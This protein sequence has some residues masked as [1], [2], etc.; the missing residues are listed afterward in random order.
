MKKVLLFFGLLL[1]VTCYSLLAL[2]T[3][4]EDTTTPEYWQNKINE[5]QTKLDELSGQK[6]TLAST[7]AYLNTQISLTQSQIAKTEQEL[8]ILEKEILE[9]SKKI[10]SLNVS[11]DELTQ[12]YKKR[13]SATYIQ[14]RENVFLTTLLNSKGIS[15]FV[16][17]YKYLQVIQNHDKKI[18]QAMERSRQNY[19]LQKSLKEQKQNELETLNNK[20]TRQKTDLSKQ[21]QEKQKLLEITNNDE[22]KFQQLLAEAIAELSAIQAIIS[23]KGTE[24]EVRD[25]KSEEN[26]ASMIQG[27][28]VCSTGTHLHFE[29]IKDQRQDNPANYLKSTEVIWDLCGR[30][31]CDSPFSFSGTYSWPINQPIRIT[32]GYGMTVYAK[33]GWYGGGPHTGIDIVSTDLLVKGIKEGKLYRGSYEVKSGC[34]ING[35][36]RYVK[37][38]HGNGFS[39]YYFHVNY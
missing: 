15:D 2:P 3:R 6:K 32:Q 33:A 26:I 29:T 8:K 38:D 4:A 14:Q 22:K 28:S 30:F 13:V 17:R 10:D 21:Q 27:T 5:Y 39:T 12:I 1:F 9:I 23:G 36:L 19:D 16:N 35:L 34:R 18:M 7:L 11:L 24:I 20:L 25:I 31:G 37:V